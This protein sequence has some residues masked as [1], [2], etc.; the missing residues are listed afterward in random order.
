MDNTTRITGYIWPYRL[1]FGI[2]ILC[3][4]AVAICWSANLSAV[5]PV[6]KIL[7]ESESLHDYVDEQLADADTRIVQETAFLA[8]I[9]ETDLNKRTKVQA[10]IADATENCSPIPRSGNMFCPMFPVTSSMPFH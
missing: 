1:T 2:S 4:V 8:T 6:V 10:R 7:F 5:G 9:D 3:A